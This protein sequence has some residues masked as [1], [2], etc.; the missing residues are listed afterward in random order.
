MVIYKNY[1]PE[2]SKG[3]FLMYYMSRYFSNCGVRCKAKIAFFLLIEAE[4]SI[5][6]FIV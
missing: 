6:I 3:M 4:E 1:T 5:I 2:N